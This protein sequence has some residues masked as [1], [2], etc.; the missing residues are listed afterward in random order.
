MATARDHSERWT[1]IPILALVAAAVLLLTGFGMGLYGEQLYR[2]QRGRDTRV[3]AGIIAASVSA[4]LAF[5]DAQTTQEYLNALRANPDI[6]AAGVY[7]EAGA[8][9]AGYSRQG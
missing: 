7:D 9:V 8:L 1:R 3:Q 6:E 2:D 5:D 4:A